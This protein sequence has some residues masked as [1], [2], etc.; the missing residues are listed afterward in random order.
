MSALV[1]ACTPPP[2]NADRHLLTPN[3]RHDSYFFSFFLPRRAVFAIMPPL[4]LLGEAVTTQE[5]N[6]HE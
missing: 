6:C 3:L 2:A 4:V 1:E 5:M